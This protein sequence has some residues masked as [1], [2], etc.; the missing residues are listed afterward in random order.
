MGNSL[1]KPKTDK[2]SQEG[3]GN[4]LRYAL[5]SMQGWR[6][7]MEDRHCIRIGLD[8]LKDWSFFAV[9]D[10]HA[11][12]HVA[13]HCAENLLNTII[14]TEK[15]SNHMIELNNDKITEQTI[16]FVKKAIEDGFLELDKQM[17][18]MPDITSG[19]DKSG[20]TAICALISKTHIFLANLGDSR[21][22]LC[23]AGNVQFV[24][25]DHKPNDPLERQ[26]IQEAGGNVMI[27]RVNGSL[28]VSRALG[29]YEYK[30]SNKKP[31]EQL[32]S[33][34][35]EVSVTK[36][37]INDEFLV[38]ACDGVWDVMTNED[39][40]AFVRY[41]MTIESSLKT[42]CSNIIDTCLHKG[43]KDNMSVVVVA[44]AGAP[45]VDANA[46]Q[47]D[48]QLNS[49]LV[50]KA[51]EIMKEK[52]NHSFQNLIEDIKQI[53]WSPLPDGV[54]LHAKYTIIEE[55]YNKYKPIQ[56]KMSSLSSL[57][58]SRSPDFHSFD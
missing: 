53:Q 57:S 19:E 5:S 32:V 30:N 52:P 54:G 22:L 26:R 4:G 38:L 21:A 39:L 44:F 45:T 2:D 6:L 18:N 24:T 31:S 56:P 33:P 37:D 16:D 15:F 28:A 9:F 51:E 7:K 11:G 41:Q 35:P 42:I 20:T 14:K 43:S 29:D 49:Q 3:D 55:I 40:C 48:K 46:Q 50:A 10:G 34:I 1:D 25:V 27:S 23:R 47:L 8:Q 36:I 17:Q 13:A 58:S 12:V